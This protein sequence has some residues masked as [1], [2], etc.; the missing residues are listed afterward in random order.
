[1]RA[2]VLHTL[3][4]PPRCEEFPE[5]VPGDGEVLI[6]VSASS[7]KPVDKQL[8]AGTHYAS[9]AELPVVCGSDGVV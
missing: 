4:K 6:Q 5:P 2:A 1:M 8:A 9:S 3:G 7:L